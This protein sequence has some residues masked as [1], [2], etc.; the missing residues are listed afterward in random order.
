MK[1]QG[2]L[3]GAVAEYRE[4]IRLGPQGTAARWNLVDVLRSQG[5][6][7]QCIAEYREAIRLEPDD[8][9]AH[10]SL[11]MALDRQGKLDD[12]IAAY[13][14]AI[15]LE[16]DNADIVG[17]FREAVRLRGKP[18]TETNELRAQMELARK[19]FGSTDPQ[20]ASALAQLGANLVRQGKWSEAEPVLRECLAIREKTQ[21]DAWNTFNTRSQLGA[22]LLGQGKYADAEPMI[23]SGYEGL[24]ARVGKNP[25]GSEK[26]LAEASERIVP[27]YEAWGKKDKAEEWRARLAKRTPAEK[28][29][30]ADL[31]Y[32]RKQF[33]A[34]ARYFTEALAAE[35]KLAESRKDQHRY[36]AACCAALAA[37]GQDKDEPHPDETARAKFRGQALEWLRAELA[38]WATALAAADPKARNQILFH[39]PHWKV[40]P[41]LACIRDPEP[42]SKLSDAER[43]D[44]KALW[45]DVDAL[46]K[47]ALK[48]AP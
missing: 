44:W 3:D 48:P 5:K 23:L 22:I 6:L 24:K 29:V 14:E 12:A 37:S 41:D 1:D 34:A 7:E 17:R 18:E 13:R 21:P 31:Y 36:N 38:A 16:P 2:N 28:L 11:G 32:D 4:A 33:A 15:R 30:F 8:A 47:R 43:K 42:L 45:S 39:V 20:T 27:L 35:P 19:K 46:I 9:F 40:D 26:R 10:F 25:A